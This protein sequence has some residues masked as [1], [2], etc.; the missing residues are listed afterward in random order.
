MAFGLRHFITAL[1][2][3]VKPQ[4]HTR[5]RTAE[6]VLKF[7]AGVA[8]FVSNAEL[9]DRPMTRRFA[10]APHINSRTHSKPELCSWLSC[11]SG[12]ARWPTAPLGWGAP[13]LERFSPI[14]EWWTARLLL[15]A[16]NTAE[17]RAGP[18]RPTTPNCIVPAKE[19]P[20]L[21]T[22]TSPSPGLETTRVRPRPGGARQNRCR[23]GRL[24]PRGE[25]GR[26]LA[27]TSEGE[28]VNCIAA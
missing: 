13:A 7:V 16:P 17:R 18:A 11:C 28:A 9:R 19:D 15:P 27:R 2:N 4:R 24:A 22:T 5:T 12:R 6:C 26:A 25:A 10:E 1:P 3:N 8:A 20:A 14:T 21:G 23:H